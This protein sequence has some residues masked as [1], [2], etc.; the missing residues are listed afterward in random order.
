L[1]HSDLK[2]LR[3]KRAAIKLNRIKFGCIADAQ[4]WRRSHVFAT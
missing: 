1:I 3:R 2:V 4:K